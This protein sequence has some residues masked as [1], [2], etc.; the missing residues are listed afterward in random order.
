MEIFIGS[1]VRLLHSQGEG[2][3]TGIKGKTIQVMLNDGFEIPFPKEALVVVSEPSKAKQQ[4]EF[5]VNKTEEK[6]IGPK[7]KK[8]SLFFIETGLFLAASE[9]KAGY[10]QIE[11]V[12]QTDLNF[13]LTLYKTGKPLHQ[14]LEV[15]ELE[16]Q[17]RATCKQWFPKIPD[18]H[19]T[20]IRI[21]WL[22]HHPDRGTPKNP[23]DF[24]LSFESVDWPGFKKK[25]PLLNKDAFCFQLDAELLP[26][27]NAEKLRD[28][29]LEKK[30]PA[31]ISKTQDID[32][33]RSLEW[34]EIDL[35]IEKLRP[36]D[37]NQLTAGEI[38]QLQL[39]TLE[40]SISKCL[41]EGIGRLI[42][43]H[44]VGSGLLKREIQQVLKSYQHVK[45]FKEAAR[46]KY[47]AGASEI[48]F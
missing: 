19:T 1:K 47:G 13:F 9:E 8:S 17:S 30:V 18:G 27:L 7:T 48:L 37:Y 3:V 39:K 42:V 6:T 46:D 43:I 44:G 25:L 33:K 26:L 15:I 5:G 34:R 20:G 23:G 22:S 21:Q 41:A 10:L 28:S 29:L 24:T 12:N 40:Q 14:F 45:D 11:L 31:P 4:P 2:I 36:K 32:L 16:P 38:L 35:H